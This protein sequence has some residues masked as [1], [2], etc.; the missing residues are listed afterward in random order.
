MV[1][2]ITLGL[3]SLGMFIPWANAKGAIVGAITSMVIVLWIG[4]GAQIALLNGQ[5][6]LDNK[7][8]SVDACPCIN[9]TEINLKQSNDNNDEVYSIYKVLILLFFTIFISS[10]L[11]LS[12]LYIF[13]FI[14]YTFIS[15][16]L[17]I[18]IRRTKTLMIINYLVFK[19][20][21]FVPFIFR[22]VI[23]GTVE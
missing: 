23:Y 13:F 8:V 11:S 3:F 4:L 19:T 18:F 9:T 12:F 6:H 15:L 22:S 16:Y 2:G 17:Y 5:I 7:P 20:L 10:L 21:I 1:G 14:F